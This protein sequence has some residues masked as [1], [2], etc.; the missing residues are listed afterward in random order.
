MSWQSRREMSWHFRQVYGLA[1]QKSG[2]SWSWEIGQE[3]QV[4]LDK[5]DRKC[6]DNAGMY[7]CLDGQLCIVK[8]D[9]CFLTRQ[10]SMTI[11]T[12]LVSKPPIPPIPPHRHL[13]PP[14]HERNPGRRRGRQHTPALVGGG[15][16]Q[17]RA[18]GG[19]HS[20]LLSSFP[21]FIY[22]GKE[23]KATNRTPG[24]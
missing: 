23:N 16:G 24:V 12:G 5:A 13:P 7:I 3:R 21:T 22:L 2:A 9:S 15:G 20:H 17:N 6:L 4:R 11:L 10:I 1:R 18:G 8:T 19:A 14:P